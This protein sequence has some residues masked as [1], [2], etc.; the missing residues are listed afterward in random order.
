MKRASGILLHI[1]S[2]SS[3]Y[4][5]G[6]LGSEAYKWVDFLKNAGQS[7]WQILPVGPTGYGD[8]PY[9]SYSTFAGNPYFVDLPA[10]EEEGLLRPEEYQNLP[11]GDD[12]ANVNFKL[13]KEHKL[14]MLRKAFSRFDFSS[15]AFQ[16]FTVTQQSWLDD[17]SLFMALKTEFPHTNWMG[18]PEGLKKREPETLETYRLR[19]KDEIDF[20]RFTQYVFFCQWKALKEHA[21]ANHIE[22][23]GDIPIYVALDSADVWANQK[24]FQLNENGVP[25]GVAGCPPDAFSETGQLWGNLLYDWE[26]QKKDGYAWWMERIRSAQKR[27][28]VIRIDHFRGFDAYYTIPYN[29]KTAENGCWVKGPGIEFFQVMQEALGDVPIIAEDLGTLTESVHKLLKESGYPGMKV[30]EFAFS[31]SEES[32]YLPHNHIKNSVVYTGTHDND[33]ARGWF[34]TL[35][36][37]D[38]NFCVQYLRLSEAEGCN[39][40]V[41]KAAW[42]SVAD[43]AVAQLQDF[44]NLG[45]EAR[46]NTPSTVGQNWKW[47]MLPDALSSELAEKILN[48]T[49]LY[50]RFEKQ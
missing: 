43:T 26:Y 7:Y 31:A 44:L 21:K 46:M 38:R 10:L 18:W 11:W 2:L 27:F 12:P 32:S 17:Y 35:S 5:I 15:P 24:L 22:I 42:A 33:T 8:S 40:G 45:S 1:T 49:K 25:F 39:W 50:G 19:L 28:D 34:E 9:Q 29:D 30:L 13:L 6:T 3:P 16:H 37:E 4:G 41:I 48:I 36:E 23:I 20:W 47:R 14:P